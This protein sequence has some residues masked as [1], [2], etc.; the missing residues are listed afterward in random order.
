MELG[1]P[2]LALFSQATAAATAA[3]SCRGFMELG[4]PNFALFSQA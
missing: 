3:A 4:N 2:N 1:N